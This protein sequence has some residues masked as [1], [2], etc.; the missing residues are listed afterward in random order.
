MPRRDLCPLTTGGFRHR[1]VADKAGKRQIPV[2][3]WR[4]RITQYNTLHNAYSEMH[5]P[6]RSREW[7][8]T[9]GEYLCR[10]QAFI[11]INMRITYT[12]NHRPVIGN[13]YIATC[14]LQPK[15][16]P[17]H[18]VRA[19]N[20]KERGKNVFLNDAREVGWTHLVLRDAASTYITTYNQW[21][22]RRRW[23]QKSLQTTHMA[24]SFWNFKAINDYHDEKE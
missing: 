1:A 13:G 4:S 8:M 18:P 21:F 6:G 17:C 5:C 23:W 7:W 19:G 20:K 14:N 9:N 3:A 11:H 15:T 24:K 2:L 16:R 10:T 12:H 22:L